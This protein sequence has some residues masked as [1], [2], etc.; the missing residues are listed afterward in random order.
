[1]QQ[2]SK[3]KRLLERKHLKSILTREEVLKN[4]KDS[5]KLVIL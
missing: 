2:Q 3:S 4:L 1:M 5:N